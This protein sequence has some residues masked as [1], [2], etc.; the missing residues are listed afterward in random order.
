[1]TLSEYSAGLMEV[2]FSDVRIDLTHEL[3]DEIY[4]ANVKAT[5]P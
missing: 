5:K 3:A 1:M 2:G 4:G